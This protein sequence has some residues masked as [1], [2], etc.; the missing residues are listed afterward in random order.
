MP[1]VPQRDDALAAAR[2][3]IT[4]DGV[5]IAQFS[6]LVEL[7]SGLDPSTLTLE[8]NDKRKLFLKKLPGKRTPP[9]VTLKRGMT[10]DLSLFAW[11]SDAVQSGVGARRDAALVMF[12]AHG[13][14]VARYHLENAWPAKV[15]IS[16]LK[17]GASEVLYEKVTL[18]CEDIQRVAL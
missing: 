13:S 2:F 8:R 14:P 15:E 6:E 4:V 17:A 9:T 10:R 3:S 16:G 7:T 18:V 12:D 11:H 5:E 1:Q